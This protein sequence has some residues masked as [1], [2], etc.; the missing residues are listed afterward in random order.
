MA[1][2]LFY[3][4][5]WIVLLLKGGTRQILLRTLGLLWFCDGFPAAPWAR[6]ANKS[7]KCF[8]RKCLVALVV[9]RL[10]ETIQRLPGSWRGT[11]QINGFV[12]GL[13]EDVASQSHP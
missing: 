4:S 3:V 10:A 9:G 8:A 1:L 13:G 12:F 7:R 6:L 5:I 11:W 2:G